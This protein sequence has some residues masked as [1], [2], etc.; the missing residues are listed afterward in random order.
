LRSCVIR[1]HMFYQKLHSAEDYLLTLKI[2]NISLSRITV[3]S[4]LTASDF[5]WCLVIEDLLYFLSTCDVSHVTKCPRLFRFFWNICI[6]SHMGEP[7]NKAR[8]LTFFQVQLTPTLWMNYT[9][10]YLH[11]PFTLTIHSYKALCYHGDSAN[12]YSVPSRS[13]T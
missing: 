11:K 7:G 9:H 5:I 8:H 12:Y 3:A 2:E 4:D 13:F 6:C 10:P 1:L